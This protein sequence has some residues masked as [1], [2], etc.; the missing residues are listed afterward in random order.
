MFKGLIAQDRL[1]SSSVYS[2]IREVLH[3]IGN[4]DFQN[5]FDLDRV[6]QGVTDEELKRYI[7]Q[8]IRAAHQRKRQPYV[9]LLNEL[10]MQRPHQSFAA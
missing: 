4:I 3:T 9:D 10:Q 8:H 2:I 6:E 5:E 1:H 7:K